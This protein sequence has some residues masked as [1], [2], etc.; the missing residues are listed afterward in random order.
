MMSSFDFPCEVLDGEKLEEWNKEDELDINNIYEINVEFLEKHIINNFLIEIGN[1]S[2]YNKK[3][4]CAYLC[5]NN[6]PKW[7]KFYSMCKYCFNS[8]VYLIHKD[9]NINYSQSKIQDI[10]KQYRKKYNYNVSITKR[11]ISTLRNFASRP[12]HTKIKTNLF[13]ETQYGV[14]HTIYREFYEGKTFIVTKGCY[15]FLLEHYGYTKFIVSVYQR[16][17]EWSNNFYKSYDLEMNVGQ[18]FYLK[19]NLKIRIRPIKSTSDDKRCVFGTLFEE[20]LCPLLSNNE[21]DSLNPPIYKDYKKL[22]KGI[23]MIKCLKTKNVF[24]DLMKEVYD[25]IE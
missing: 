13:R 18:K 10:I 12:E 8:N 22:Y 9:I 24:E 11:E 19:G 3:K 7:C 4:K 1:H 15:L 20:Y 23:L 14:F 16:L 5:R 6:F 2:Y 21:H 25:F 17:I